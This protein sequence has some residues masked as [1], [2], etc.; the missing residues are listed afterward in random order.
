MPTRREAL[1]AGAFA[2]AGLATGSRRSRAAAPMV[3]VRMRSD[4]LGAEVWFDPVGVHI[5]PGTAVRWVVES[6]VHTSTAYHP[7]NDG[8]PLRIPARAAPW[9]S[10]FLIHPGDS[11]TVRFDVPGVYDYC[12]RPHEAAGMVG[13]IV[14]GSVPE[15]WTGPAP[16]PSERPVPE[17]ALEAFPPVAE[18][19][20]RGRVR[21]SG[22]R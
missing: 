15:D 14:V 11:Y 18:I 10:G 16:S 9:D 1:Q 17:A 19:I 4:R 12:C 8:R 20:R 6:N 21:R 5:P 7:A 13:R 2:L 3:V 22:S